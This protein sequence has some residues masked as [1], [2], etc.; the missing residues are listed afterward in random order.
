MNFTYP[1]SMGPHIK[2]VLEGE[3]EVSVT[4]IKTIIDLGANVGSFTVW[5]SMKWPGSK[6]HC[7]EPSESN[8]NLL[9][10][11]IKEVKN[12]DVICNKAAVGD[13]LLTKLFKG[14]NNPG[15]CSLFKQGEQQD[16]FEEIKTISPE[17]LPEADI[18]KLDIEG[19]EGYVLKVLSEKNRLTFPVILLEYHGEKVRREVCKVVH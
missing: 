17:S 8:F 6:I 11:N 1:T 16:V 3:Y 18:L 9:I 15:E 12:C 5:A 2:K 13:P 19:S 10:S 4:G 7:Y 14:L